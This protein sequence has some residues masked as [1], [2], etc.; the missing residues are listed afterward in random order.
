MKNIS[1]TS[2]EAPS[3]LPPWEPMLTLSATAK[4]LCVSLRQ[5]YRLI[6]DGKLPVVMVST[7]S[8]R[9]RPSDLRKYLESCTVQH[10]S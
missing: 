9:L 5:V 6:A 7:R 8:P 3:G 2:I 1:P 10:G 4:F